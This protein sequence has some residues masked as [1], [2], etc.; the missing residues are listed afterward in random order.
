MMKG[1]RSDFEG[2]K[3]SSGKDRHRPTKE[4]MGTS[5]DEQADES[6]QAS[7]THHHLEIRRPAS[8]A[9]GFCKLRDLGAVLRDVRAEFGASEVALDRIRA[10]LGFVP[11]AFERAWRF[12]KNDPIWGARSMWAPSDCGATED[13]LKPTG[14]NRMCDRT[15]ASYSSGGAV[16]YVTSKPVA[17]GKAATCEKFKDFPAVAKT[18]S[19]IEGYECIDTFPVMTFTGAGC[20]DDFTGVHI[21]PTFS[22]NRPFMLEFDSVHHESGV[23]MPFKYKH[24]F[25]L[26][27]M[28][29]D[30]LRDP[31]TNKST[32]AKWSDKKAGVVWRGALT[33]GPPPGVAAVQRCASAESHKL[34]KMFRGNK[35]DLFVPG[36]PWKCRGRYSIASDGTPLEEKKRMKKN[37][38]KSKGKKKGKARH[39]EGEGE[40]GNEEEDR[41]AEEAPP[42]PYHD[43]L[44]RTDCDRGLRILRKQASRLEMVQRWQHAT[45]E[46]DGIDVKFRW[47]A[48]HTWGKAKAVFDL[49][50]VHGDGGSMVTNKSMSIGEQ[51]EHKYVLAVEGVDKSSNIQWVMMSGS[52]LV[53]PPPS[54]ESWLLEGRLAPWV[55]YAPVRPDFKDLKDVV[56][57][58]REHDDEA[59]KMARASKL[60]MRQF[61]DHDY[62]FK[63]ASGVLRLYVAYMHA[64]ATLRSNPNAVSAPR[65]VKEKIEMTGQC[66][67]N[68]TFQTKKTRYTPPTEHEAFL[69]SSSRFKVKH[70]THLQLPVPFGLTEGDSFFVTVPMDEDDPEFD[71]N[72]VAG[73]PYDSRG[74]VPPI[75]IT[76]PG[77]NRWKVNKMFKVAIQEAG[78]K[79]QQ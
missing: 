57:W 70:T 43:D 38:K 73:V 64:A 62:E 68:A 14:C 63:I 65:P 49:C 35:G 72:G 25:V 45:M 56:N 79:K 33:A 16:S 32:E 28:Y 75:R 67:E 27:R 21:A 29:M 40:E 51:L 13:T 69:Q 37:N 6:R 77:Q 7:K 59:H 22:K 53:M 12:P 54:Q 66:W 41:V 55:H 4:A 50:G 52:V 47:G 8:S 78:G 1:G 46:A 71:P 39:L 44:H 2:I 42:D 60:Y 18:A 10:S 48:A 76:V 17:V 36:L 26:P 15:V 19:T 11:E 61:G 31:E 23:V 9:S 34:S 24:H 30:N 74:F 20:N 5:P 3:D 58:L